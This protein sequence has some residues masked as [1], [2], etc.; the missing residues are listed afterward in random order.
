[1]VL[2]VHSIVAVTIFMASL[3][4]LWAFADELKGDESLFFSAAVACMSVC[5]VCLLFLG[6]M[7]CSC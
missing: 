1:M 5:C 6:A 7:L 3:A 4:G 2:D